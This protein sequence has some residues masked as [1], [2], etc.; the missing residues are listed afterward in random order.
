VITFS[1]LDLFASGGC[2]GVGLANALNGHPGLST[3]AFTLAAASIAKSH[4]A[5]TAASPFMHRRLRQFVP[6]PM[7]DI[8]DLRTALGR[9]PIAFNF[10]TK[11]NPRAFNELPNA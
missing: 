11:L 6:P 10:G 9:F 5:T 7:E 8:F 3:I 1:I 4:R 2:A